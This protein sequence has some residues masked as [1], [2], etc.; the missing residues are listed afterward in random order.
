MNEAQFQTYNALPLAESCRRID[1]DAVE[2]LTL[3]SNP[4]QYVLVVNGTKPFLN[5][6]VDLVPL[7]YIR[8]PAY[9]GIE[10]VGCLGGIG[11]PAEASYTVSLHLSGILGTAGI[12][13]IGATRTEQHEVPPHDVVGTCRDWQA[14]HDR[15]PGATPTLH[16]TGAC[17]FPTAGYSVVLRRHEPQGINPRDLLLDRVVDAP[18]GP[19]AEVITVVEVHYREETDV[20]YDTVTILPDQGSVPVE[21]VS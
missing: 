18:S 16:V 11:L 6:D 13:V 1:F 15:Q 2:I 12:E 10:V 7:V 21:Q 20:A 3:E 4:P 9:W 17:E 5:M 14:W 8:Q 19:V